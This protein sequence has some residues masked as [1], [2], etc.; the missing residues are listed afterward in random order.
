MNDGTLW[1]VCVCV[2][3]LEGKFDRKK[4][5]H[6]TH[7]NLYEGVGRFHSARLVPRHEVRACALASLFAHLCWGNDVVFILFV[8]GGFTMFLFLLLPPVSN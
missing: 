1:F 3:P 8:K 5:C 4:S 2:K 6:A 7:Q